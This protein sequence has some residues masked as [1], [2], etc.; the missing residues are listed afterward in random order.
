MSDVRVHNHGTI[1]TFELLTTDAEL[2]V[3][4]AVVDPMFMLGRL[5]V[6]HRYARALAEGMLNDGLEVE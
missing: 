2:W 6:E 5:I 3:E 4:D 1:F